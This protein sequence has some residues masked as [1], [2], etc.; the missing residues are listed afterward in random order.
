VSA[1]VEYQLPKI[2]DV[3][4]T[5]GARTPWPNEAIAVDAAAPE[6]LI[7]T[8]VGSDGFFL[9]D[10]NPTQMMQGRNSL[11]AYN[12]SVPPDMAVCDQVT[13]LTGTAT[14]FYGF[15]QLGFPTWSLVHVSTPAAPTSLPKCLVPEPIAID[16]NWLNGNKTTIA[17][18]LYPYEASVVRLEG[19][20]LP[21]YLGATPATGNH[22]GPGKSNC[23]FNGDG[24]IDYT[25]IAPNCPAPDMCEGDCSTQCDATP[26]CSNWTDFSAR[27]EVKVNLPGTTSMIKINVSTVASFDVLNNVGKTLDVVTGSLTEFSGGNL[28]WTVETRCQDDLVCPA[29]M[30]CT[31]Q[32]IVPIT[33]ACV[34]PPTIWDNDEGTD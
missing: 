28:N 16:P 22:F 15:T 9:T 8:R 33:K 1:A 13:L 32:T 19:F 26:A 29:D 18:N 24:Q 3:R 7:V 5:D 10:I 4:G 20:Q 21:L 2:S 30:G 17:Q 12:F 25:Q 6:Q 14:D 34:A 23:D 11:F 27:S 31:T